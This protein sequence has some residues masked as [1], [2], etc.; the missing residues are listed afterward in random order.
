MVLPGEFS[1]IV[2][3][4]HEPYEAGCSLSV[5][6]VCFDQQEKHTGFVIPKKLCMKKGRLNTSFCSF[7]K[8]PLIKNSSKQII[9]ELYKIY[10]FKKAS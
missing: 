2:G 6:P 1:C 7:E 5:N 3:E 4:R 10:E 9:D 8:I